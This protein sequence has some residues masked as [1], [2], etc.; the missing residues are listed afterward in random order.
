MKYSRPRTASRSSAIA[1]LAALAS[2]VWTA[3]AAADT[4]TPE[5][6]TEEL[7]AYVTARLPDSVEAVAVEELNLREPLAVDGDVTLRFRARAGEDY[8]GRTV[9]SMDLLQEDRV[10]DTR[11]LGFVVRGEASV[12]TVAQPVGRGEIVDEAS[13]VPNHRDLGSLPSDAILAEEPLGHATATR[14][15]TVGTVLCRSMMRAVP[16][17]ARGTPVVIEIRRGSLTVSCAG[18]VLADASI[19]GVVRARCEETGATLMGRLEEGGRVVVTLPGAVA[20]QAGGE[21]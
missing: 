9:L 6:V 5:R 20:E 10:L 4:V 17:Q 16:D 15:L 11:N 8:L 13:L 7:V 21:R 2:L 12:W 18:S 19:G 14:N 1:A 3:P